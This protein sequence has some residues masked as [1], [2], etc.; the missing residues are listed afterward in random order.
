MNEK[1]YGEQTLGPD[2]GI[3]TVRYE[4]ATGEGVDLTASVTNGILTQNLHISSGATGEDDLFGIERIELSDNADHL[5]VNSNNMRF[6]TTID[7]KG[8]QDGQR[9]ILDFSGLNSAVS[10]KQQGI[11]L[12]VSGGS[13]FG[14]LSGVG[15]VTYANFEEVILTSKNDTIDISSE[16]VLDHGFLVFAINTQARQPRSV[17]GVDERYPAFAFSPALSMPATA[18]A[19][20]LSDVSPLTPTAPSRTLPSVINTPPGTG[21]RRPCASVFTASTK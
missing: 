17:G 8:Q 21:T 2:A 10:L 1:F 19:S 6:A 20:S 14:S 12:Y 16:M 7:A 13:L 4:G 3:D 11:D 15:G 9:D 5:R 18:Q